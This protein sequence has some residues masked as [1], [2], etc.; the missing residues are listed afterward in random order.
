[1]IHSKSDSFR[2]LW[3]NLRASDTAAADLNILVLRDIICP[4]PQ[5]GVP[6][7]GVHCFNRFFAGDGSHLSDIPGGNRA[8]H[9]V[10]E[11]TALVD[12]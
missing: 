7:V 8:D 5:C 9:V 12:G 2:V 1:M 3:G 6:H 4:R 11:I 10:G